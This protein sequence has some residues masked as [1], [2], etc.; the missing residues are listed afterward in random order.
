M[1]VFLI[2]N[3]KMIFVIKHKKFLAS[4]SIFGV[5]VSKLYH[6]KKSCVIILLEVYKNLKIA[7]YFIILPL[8]LAV[9]LQIEDN[10]KFLVD[11][12]KRTW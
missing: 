4:A 2:E 11:I 3:M 12:E 1:Q 5:V 10:K 9:Y 6:K 7:F 8:I